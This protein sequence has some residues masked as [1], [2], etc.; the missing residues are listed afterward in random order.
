MKIIRT[1]LHTHN[2]WFKLQMCKDGFEGLLKIDSLKDISTSLVADSTCKA[3]A[4][5]CAR[6]SSQVT[7]SSSLTKE[8]S[9]SPAQV[10]SKDALC[11]ESA[12]IKVMVSF[13]LSRM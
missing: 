6:D 5:T 4:D 10:S 2:E 11:E 3:I 7:V 12:I 9:N 13:A 8:D 1:T